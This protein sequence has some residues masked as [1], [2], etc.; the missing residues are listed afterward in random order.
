MLL[1]PSREIS[2]SNIYNWE[3]TKSSEF[4]KELKSMAQAEVGP[5]IKCSWGRLFELIVLFVL[6][7]SQVLQFCQG[8]WHSLF[9]MPLTYWVLGVNLFHDASHFG[10]SWNWRVNRLA[11]NAGF[12]FS[13][14]YTWYHQHVIGHHCF[15]NIMGKD[16][17]LYHAPKVIRH[18]ADVRYRV[19]HWYQTVTFVITWLLGVPMSLIWHGMIQSYRKPRYNRV[20]SFGNTKYLNPKSLI[21]RFFAYFVIVHV[22]PFVFHGVS[23][24][25]VIFAVVP[26]YLFSVFFMISTQINHLTPDTTEQFDENFFIHQIKTSHNVATD[27]YFLYLFTGGLNMQIEHHLFPS[28]NHCHLKRLTPKVK[29]LCNKYK[30][31]YCES[32]SLWNALCKHVEHLRKFSS[33]E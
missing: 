29:E 8:Y 13:A 27:N 31:N 9:T 5:N 14:P 22:M 15:P 23:V 11:T 26:I 18:S 19:A 25:G 28:V 7:A 1:P 6:A 4:T 24:K 3:L 2:P 20:V 33:K 30:V 10:L 21:F 17:D 16:P 12:C 32:H